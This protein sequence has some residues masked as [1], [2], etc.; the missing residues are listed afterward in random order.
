MASE[1][2]KIMRKTIASFGAAIAALG[3]LGFSGVAAASSHREAPAI[4]QDPVAD[5]TDLWAWHTGDASTGKLH[6]VM[7]YNPMEEPSGGPNFHSF[8]DDVLYEL[9][10]ARGSASLEDVVTYQFRFSTSAAPIVDPADLTLPVGGGKEF[11]SQLS[12]RKQTF[13]VTEVKGGVSTVIATDVEV[14]PPNIGPRTNTVAYGL[15]Q[16]TKAA[17]ETFALSKAKPTNGGG[18]VWAGPR[19]D[20][21]YVDLGGFFDLANLRP[22]GTAQDGVAGYNCHAISFDIPAASIPTVAANDAFKDRLGVWTSASRR[23][24]TILRNDGSKQGF[25]PWVQVSRLG[26]P[27]INEV[28]IGIQDKDKFSRTHPKDDVTNYGAYILNPVAVR[29]AEAVGI[30]TALGVPANVVTS[31]KSGRTDI[32]TAMNVLSDPT[33]P[34][35]FPLTSTGDVL[36]VDFGAPVGFPN[37]RP[38][39]PALTGAANRE[40]DVTDILATVVLAGLQNLVDAITPGGPAGLLISDGVDYND[41]NYTDAFPYLPTPWTGYDEGKGKPTPL[42]PPQALAPRASARR[43]GFR[44]L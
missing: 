3:I 17:Y 43:R 5:S 35:G 21:F 7:A 8:G 30:Y 20:G 33:A 26:L 39:G 36:R 37:G 41:A 12:G 44:F 18:L 23:K 2:R 6:V 40:N 27:L 1:G 22:K 25:G 38:L 29:D 34:G 14:A 32:V 16:N 24:M 11:F 31:L 42:A 19:D 28:V 4:S 10:I 15:P 13:S 9:H